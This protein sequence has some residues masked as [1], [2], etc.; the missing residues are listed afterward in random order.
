MP[1]TQLQGN[2]VPSIKIFDLGITVAYGQIVEITNQQYA[3]SLNAQALVKNRM[4]S[5]IVGPPQTPT[6]VNLSDVDPF[7]FNVRPGK[8][9]LEDCSPALQEMI[10]AGGGW[11]FLQDPKFTHNPSTNVI[12]WSTGIILFNGVPYTLAPSTLTATSTS[13]LIATLAAGVATLS[14]QPTSFTPA[15]NQI[16][17]GSYDFT[18]HELILVKGGDTEASEVT[19]DPTGRI[20]LTQPSVQLVLNALDSYL[21]G[22]T[23]IPG[24]FFIQPVNSAINLTTLGTTGPQ[25]IN[26]TAS[27]ALSFVSG[28][29]GSGNAQIIAA[30]NLLFQSTG[31]QTIHGVGAN[32]IIQ[33]VATVFK[34]HTSGDVL[35]SMHEDTGPSPVETV[36]DFSQATNNR[37]HII[38]NN[39]MVFDLSAASES[40]VF[41][42]LSAGGAFQFKG[43]APIVLYGPGPGYVVFGAISTNNV[44]GP[45][46]A[47]EISTAS[48]TDLQLAPATGAKILNSG[49]TVDHTIAINDLPAGG[50][51]GAAADTVDQCSSF[52]LDQTTAAQTV[53]LPTPT[54]ATAGRKADVLNIGTTPITLYGKTLTNGFGATLKWSG[55]AWMLMGVGG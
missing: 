9:E 2:T 3:S 25:P 44:I 23:K 47:L 17:V 26:I 49:P 19:F 18:N 5:L 48:A 36:L 14:L 35:L 15:S 42:F 29:G 43:G 41:E 46:A 40:P 45:G 4:L 53:T 50:D 38:G 16:I 11:E 12:S 34:D 32:L 28:L 24:P 21:T 54:D 13:L 33:N 7:T 10:S 8:L 22:F 20:I 37:L 51:I 31:G 52:T 30:G 39:G 1:N 27:G 55:S 6:L